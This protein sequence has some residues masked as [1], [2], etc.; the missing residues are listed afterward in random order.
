MKLIHTADWHLGDSLYG[1]D[2]TAE[3]A[4]FLQWLFDTIR[5]QQPD[6]L[7]VSG[8]IFD[9]ANPS[10]QAERQLFDFLTQLTGACKGLKV[11]ITAGNHDSGYR[12]EAPRALYGRLGIE[13]R[14]V[15]PHDDK[16][17]PDYQ[18]LLVPLKPQDGGPE[19]VVMAV[20]YLRPDDLEPGQNQSQS[21][22]KF[23]E[24]LTAT[25]RK[26]YGAECPLVLMAHFYAVGSEINA[27]EH[28][29]RLVVGGQD[30]VDAENLSDGIAYTALGHIHK[31]QKVAGQA[32]VRYAGSPLPMTFSEK[33][34][35]HSV[36][37]V[38]ISSDKVEITPLPYT[39]LRGMLTVPDAGSADISEVLKQLGRLPKARKGEDAVDS[40][41]DAPAATD[42]AAAD[43]ADS[44]PYL[45]VRVQEIAPDPSLAAAI[46]K[47]LDGKAV[48][49]CRVVRVRPNGDRSGEV[50][51]MMSLED[52]KKI[53]PAQIA[54]NIYKSRYGEEMP[55]EVARLF[56]EVKR[57]CEQNLNAKGEEG[58]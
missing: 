6:A 49:L 12:L 48:R 56:A 26:T 36:T 52:L 27:E 18:S 32:S 47:A 16:G 55:D 24:A 45:E 53:N 7:L 9:N 44:W 43:A 42:V 21:M 50:A 22:R 15:V 34:Y 28:S 40:S 25:A 29:E 30:A 39:P 57:R 35:H 5:E 23:F 8:D 58:E 33:N 41:D 3:H 10:A 37:L 54:R 46:V 11:I 13:V 31:A 14:G 38:D 1:F 17:N 51:P 2:R 19:V 4:H 20:P